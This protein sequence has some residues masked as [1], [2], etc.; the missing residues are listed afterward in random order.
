MQTPIY[1]DYNA[2]TPI[3]REVVDAMLPFLL[4]HFGNPSSSH[5][6]GGVAHEAVERA[7]A[8]VAGLIGCLP[9]EI[10]FT[11]AGSEANNLAIKGV[12][13]A[14]RG[15][16][17]HLIASAVE[18]PA[19]LST[20]R[21]LVERFGYRLTVLPVDGTGQ[22]DPDDVRRAIEP[23]TVLVTVM[24]ANN[25]TGTL[26]PISEIAEITRE[27]GVRF[28]TD[29]A[30]SVGKVPT[31]V[32]R[33]RV[34]LLTIVGHKLNAPKG[35]G[36]LYVR[37]GTMLDSLVHGAGPEGGRRAGT[38][39]VPYMVALGA[40]CAL[41]GRRLAAGGAAQVQVMR[42]RLHARLRGAVPGL[43]LNGH[44]EQRLP[45]TLNVSFPGQDGEELLARTPA[46]AASTGSACHAGRTEPSGVLTAM[47]VERGRA[48]GAVRLSLGYPTTDAEADR[49]AT[50]LLDSVRAA[51]ASVS[52]AIDAVGPG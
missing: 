43:E 31:D 49:A 9:H 50:A 38:E 17:D 2:T 18:H 7:R 29:A 15:Q 23:G 6:Y 21:Y 28:H 44:P 16:G 5:A 25:E 12:A 40:A 37:E 30:Q 3:D 20:C 48:L 36:A 14:R 47:G 22:V 13:L 34:H 24:H 1:L 32:E 19:V 27:H 46:V 42:D 26:E 39:N 41:A 52:D 8:Q 51:V 33:L 45:N 11:G 35:I 10:V 4:E